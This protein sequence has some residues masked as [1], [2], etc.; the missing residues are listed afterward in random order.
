MQRNLYCLNV[1]RFGVMKVTKHRP[2][3][4]ES[5]Y[6]KES[7]SDAAAVYAASLRNAAEDV[8]LDASLDAL[9]VELGERRM[10][11]MAGKDASCT[12]SA[13]DKSR[14]E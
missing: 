3:D 14:T 11:G 4:K 13:S 12:H 9:Y 2:S 7:V 6:F 5:T 8:R 1:N 10:G